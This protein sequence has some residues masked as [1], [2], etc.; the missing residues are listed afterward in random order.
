MCN[1]PIFK[2]TCCL[3]GAALFV[4]ATLLAQGERQRQQVVMNGKASIHVTVRGRG[5]PIVFIPSFGRGVHDFDELS[6]RLARS[7]YQTILPEPRGIGSSTGPLEGI[8]LHD[9]AADVAAV[10]QAVGG[11]S[12]IV[13]GHGFGSR[14]ARTVATDHPGLVKHSVLLACGGTVAMSE[15]NRDVFLRVF[16]PSL[17]KKER[18][19]AIG[20]VFFANGH[21]PKV[22]EGGWY[23]DTARAQQ[24]ANAATSVREWWVGGSAP[25]LVLHRRRLCAGAPPQAGQH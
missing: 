24:A 25:I 16:D 6:K 11:G 9:L 4:P 7:G 17:P 14:V 12:A 13:T 15:K 21:D 1:E 18:V 8:T 20:S 19:A 5:V 3:I 10:I 23:F 2:A 22:W